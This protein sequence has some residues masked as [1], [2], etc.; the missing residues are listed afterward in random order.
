MVKCSHVRPYSRLWFVAIIQRNRRWSDALA[1]ARETANLG[2]N[3]FVSSAKC[4]YLCAHRLTAAYP[5][6]LLLSRITKMKSVIAVAFLLS[7]VEKCAGGISNPQVTVSTR[8]TPTCVQDQT[9]NLA[10]RLLWLEVPM[11]HLRRCSLP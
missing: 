5:V 6:P 11:I 7:L 4:T 2:F 1:K 3:L 9:T 8:L 10:F